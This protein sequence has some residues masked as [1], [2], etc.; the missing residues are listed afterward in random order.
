MTAGSPSNRDSGA[1]VLV[2]V[3]VAGGAL[4]VGVAVAGLVDG[5]AV[6]GVTVALADD[7]PAACG[8]AAL[9]P[10]PDSSSIPTAT[11]TAVAGRSLTHGACS[12][13]S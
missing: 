10:H 12:P 7:V 4:V 9:L 5:V 6:V 13:W 8:G 1:T 3:G 11:A 2:G